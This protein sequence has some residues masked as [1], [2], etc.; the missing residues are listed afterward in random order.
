[1][2]VRSAWLLA[3]GV[4]AQQGAGRASVH[5]NQPRAEARSFC[6]AAFALAERRRHCRRR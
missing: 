5:T 3:D 6:H 1:M 4:K 2:A